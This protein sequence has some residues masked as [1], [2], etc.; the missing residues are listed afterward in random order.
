MGPRPCKVEHN[1]ADGERHGQGCPLSG[2]K[3][4]GRQCCGRNRKLWVLKDKVSHQSLWGQLGRNQVDED[5]RRQEKGEATPLFPFSDLLLLN[6][7]S[8]T[9]EGSL[10]QGRHSAT[11][12]PK[13]F[14][15]MKTAERGVILLIVLLH[16]QRYNTW[17]A[18]SGK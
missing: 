13:Q 10:S 1:A 9:V 18:E 6:P 8:T 2:V 4:V 17:R 14:S 12:N 16:V 11:D 15:L 3:L 7:A 5:K